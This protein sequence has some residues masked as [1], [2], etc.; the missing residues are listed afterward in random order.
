MTD[1]ELTKAIGIA[2]WIFR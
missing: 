2:I 1:F